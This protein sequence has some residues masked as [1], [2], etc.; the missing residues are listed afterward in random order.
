MRIGIITLP[1][2]INY[3][4]I[5]QAYALQITLKNLGHQSYII[6][7]KKTKRKGIIFIVK[8]FLKFILYP[9]RNYFGPQ[10]K[11]T[12][13]REAINKY[14]QKFIKNNI[15]TKYVSNLRH[16]SPNKFDCL[17]AGSDQV[18]R[19]LYFKNIEN[20]FFSFAENW[21]IRRIAYAVSFGVNSWEYTEEQTK[22]CLKLIKK[23]NALSFRERSGVLLCKNNFHRDSI[24]VIDPT[25]LL[26]RT[27]YIQLFSC[28][29]NYT[30]PGNLMVYFINDSVK[31]NEFVDNVSNKKNMIP[32]RVYGKALDNTLPL[33]QRVQP[34]VEQWLK[35]FYDAELVITDSFHA[36]VFSIIFNKPFWVLPNNSGGLSRIES[37]LSTFNLEDCLIRDPN[38]IPHVSFNF[39]EI[40]SKLEQLKK[41]SL[42]FL[43]QALN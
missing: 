25:M 13:E 30:S 29:R 39:N 31:N 18:W 1:L 21:N 15:N 5:L 24:Q 26:D 9:F 4:G 22:T 7:E 41:E 12:Y 10:I 23:F 17:I 27:N 14:C 3:G 8:T 42:S 2:H 37:L 34:P 36:C 38:S 19:P 32:F 16:I 35:G 43:I 28:V 11:R 33:S 20:A 6:E 40:N